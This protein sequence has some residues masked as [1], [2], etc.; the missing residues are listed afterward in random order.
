MVFRKY[1]YYGLPKFNASKYIV[2]CSDDLKP[3]SRLI[4]PNR[5][6][7]TDFVI[8]D[9]DVKKANNI[10][11][12]FENGYSGITLKSRG[13]IK[14]KRKMYKKR[15]SSLFRRKNKRLII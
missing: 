4:K 9:E 1:A 14:S 2:L 8:S 5:L 7:L 12:R 11:Y 15:A 13:C 10:Y 6:H 3:E